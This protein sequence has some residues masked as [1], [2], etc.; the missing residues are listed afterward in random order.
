M[1]TLL[2]IV[3]LVIIVGEVCFGVAIF[4]YYKSVAS[5]TALE[6]V[7]DINVLSL[8]TKDSFASAARE[9][10]EGFKFRDKVEVQIFDSNGDILVTTNGFA[11]ASVYQ[12]PPTTAM[13]LQRAVRQSGTAKMPTASVFWRSQPCCPI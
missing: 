5:D 3:L 4:T 9:Y 13:P 8:S 6:Y 12:R 10:A 2:P 7:R 11:S 1:Y